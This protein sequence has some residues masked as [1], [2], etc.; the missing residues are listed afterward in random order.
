MQYVGCDAKE[1]PN[2]ANS[3][4]E[5]CQNPICLQHAHVKTDVHYHSVTATS[6]NATATATATSYEKKGLCPDCYYMDYKL[7]RAG[8]RQLEGAKNGR[9]CAAVCCIVFIIG[10]IITG[11]MSF[12]V[13]INCLAASLTSANPASAI[14]AGIL[15]LCI[16][17]IT[18]AICCEESV[19]GK[20]AIREHNQSV[21]EIQ[22]YASK[23]FKMNHHN[24]N[25]HPYKYQIA[26]EVK[27]F[28][29]DAINKA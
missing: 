13:G 3:V 1:C 28:P 15:L 11:T 26:L 8:K 23:G 10:I 29:C 4:C 2:I 27:E 20:R 25:Y 9:F 21:A 22:Q 24:G 19:Y 7:F 16:G 14:V 17:C 18:S 6:A 5:I 12:F